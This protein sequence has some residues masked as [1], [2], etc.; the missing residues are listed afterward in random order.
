[1]KIED[2]KPCGKKVNF[3]PA[4]SGRKIRNVLKIY[5]CRRFFRRKTFSRML[6]IYFY[7]V[8]MIHF[9]K[10]MQSQIPPVPRTNKG[11]VQKPQIFPDS[12]RKLTFFPQ[13]FIIMCPLDSVTVHFWEQLRVSRLILRF[14]MC[15]RNQHFDGNIVVPIKIE[16]LPH[17]SPMLL[18]KARKPGISRAVNIDHCSIHVP[19]DGSRSNS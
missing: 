3:R 7:F 6:F 1:M 15:F 5:F 2:M 10:K 11:F 17:P 8:D 18:F 16:S 9:T 14:T 19:V 13:G 4:K 12:G